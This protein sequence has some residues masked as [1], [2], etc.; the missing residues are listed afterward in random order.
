MDDHGAPTIAAPPGPDAPLDAE[1][2]R[3]LA[4]L[5]EKAAT[6]PD[7]YPL[8]LNALRTATNQSTSRDPVVSYDDTT[9]LAA[10]QRLKDRRL[11][12][13]VHAAQGARST[14]YRHVLDE[15][16]ELDAAALAVLAVLV[17]RGPQTTT[18]LRTRTERAHRFDSVDAVDAT[19]A[20]LARRDPPLVVTLPRQ[21]GQKE[22]RHAHLLGGPV[23]ADALAA[24]AAPA[25]PRGGLADRVAALEAR[26]ER[27]EA[28]LGVDA[29]PDADDDAGA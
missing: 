19:L 20:E 2:L 6:V 9:L 14:R 11:V 13:F 27:L 5:I 16:L 28:L 15:R 23:D 25:A 18:E 17:L 4:A 29:D 22:P 24:A 3:V 10:L 8:T 7:S 1:E 21:P 26:L 12:R